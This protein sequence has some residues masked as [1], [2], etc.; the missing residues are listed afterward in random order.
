[1]SID[2]E[3]AADFAL[4]GATVEVDGD[5]DDRCEVW[6]VNWPSVLLFLELETQ[7]RCV[8]RG[9]TGVLLWL[10]LDYGAVADVLEMRSKAARRR[11]SN[12]RV[13]EDLR[14]L[15]REA[16]TIMNEAT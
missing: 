7:W 4:L 8:A 14:I 9:M 13:F 10:G 6:N 2:A 15:E 3:I 16:L 11:R 12:K 1:M 5:D